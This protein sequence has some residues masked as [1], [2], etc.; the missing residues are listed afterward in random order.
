[1]RKAVSEAKGLDQ[2]GVDYAIL[3]GAQLRELE[4]HVSEK[5]RWGSGWSRRLGW[6]D[7]P[8]FPICFR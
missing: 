2:Y 3:T 8:A 7:A 6:G 4:P 1:M 5:F